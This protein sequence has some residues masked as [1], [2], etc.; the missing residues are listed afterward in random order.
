M[1]T[2]IDYFKP[3]TSDNDICRQFWDE[4]ISNDDKRLPFLD[5]NNVLQ[6]LLDDYF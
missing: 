4:I 2:T 3:M 5:E 6:R 1:T